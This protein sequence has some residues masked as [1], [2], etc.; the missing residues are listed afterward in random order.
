MINKRV[1]IKDVIESQ[2]PR[3]VLEDNPKFADFLRQYYISQEFQG[4]A[5]DLAENLDQ[6]IKLDNLVDNVINP[7]IILERAC[8]STDTEIVLSSS[9]GLPDE[10]GLIKIDDEIITYTERDNNTIKGCIRGFSGISKY[11]DENNPEEL[12]F[13]STDLSLIH[14]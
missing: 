14:I 3:F 8:T 11:R 12:I 5:I 10:Y 13:E 9:D 6:Y 2:L 7:D 1:K 4:G